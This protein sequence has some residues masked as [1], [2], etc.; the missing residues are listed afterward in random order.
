[1]VRRTL[2]GAS[3]AA[4]VVAGTVTYVVTSGGGSGGAPSAAAS[5]PDPGRVYQYG[6][7]DLSSSAAKKKVVGFP[8]ASTKPFSLL[9]VTWEK[10]DAELKGTVRVRTRDAASGKWSGWRV[11]QPDTDDVPDARAGDRAGTSGLWVG[12]SNGVE[13][14]VAGHGR[15]LPKGLRVDLIDPGKGTTSVR[16]GKTSRPRAAGE[17]GANVRLA[18]ATSPAGAAVAQAAPS[19]DAAVVTAPRP[20]IVS[21]AQWGAD[22]SLIKDPVQ[23]DA[24]VKAVFVHHSDTGNSYTCAQAPS[25]VKSI[26][27]YHV[28]SLGWNDIGYNFLVDKC[29]TIYAGRSGGLARPVHG[30]HTYGFNTDTSGIAVLGTYTRKDQSPSGV[31][32]TQAALTGVAKVAAWKLSLTGVDPAGKTT[33]TSNVKDGKYPYGQKVSFYTISGHRDGFATA[34]PV[35]QL[36][37]KLGAIRTAAKKLVTPSVAAT[38]TGATNVSGRYYTKST[39]TVGWKPVAG[40]TYDVRVDGA[41]AAKPAAGA[42]SAQVALKP[43]THKVALH[44]DFGS[45]TGDSAAYTVVADVTKPVFATPPALVPRRGTVE[46]TAVPVTLGWKATDNA[47]IRS[48]RAT[49]P[50][51]KTFAG[52][53]TGWAATATP[54]AA[55]SWALTAADAAGNTASSAI[56]RS[57]AL[58]AEGRSKRT[59][60]WKQVPKTEPYLGGYGLYAKSKGASASWTFT[61]RAVGLIF[62]RATYTGAVTV[63]VDGKSAG[64]LDTRASATAFRQIAWT[65]SWAASGKH[66][67]KIV[68][69]GTSGR[70]AVGIDGL[71]YVG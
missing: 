21:R 33:L 62:K 8:A 47:L 10:A 48:V 44:A 64:T 56:S 54:G 36:Y 7:R 71:A 49:S 19:L 57:V 3:V 14:R 65:R 50:A 67:I 66:T 1:M 70:P 29:G 59:G 6:L 27:L 34:C 23:Y 15:T 69:A 40:A 17:G 61:G 35:D 52:T 37:A 4:V 20:A 30:A 32:P 60:V 55:Q 58:L 24:S 11:V 43:G 41:V 53:A 16:G 13:V 25:V 31:A 46:T 26:F 12:P 38:L 51:A 5:R 63:Y 18:A 45:S 2:V 39:V 22:D 68:V 42:T 9:G 28:K